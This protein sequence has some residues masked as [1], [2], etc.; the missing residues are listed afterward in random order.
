M[1]KDISPRAFCCGSVGKR[2]N[3]KESMARC[4]AKLFFEMLPFTDDATAKRPRCV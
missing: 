2:S 3:F 4:F 1:L